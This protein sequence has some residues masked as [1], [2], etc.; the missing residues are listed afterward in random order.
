M[1]HLFCQSARWSLLCRFHL[2]VKLQESFFCVKDPCVNEIHLGNIKSVP[3]AQVQLNI[4]LLYREVEIILF[5]SCLLGKRD[6]LLRYVP[7]DPTQTLSQVSTWLIPGKSWG[8]HERGCWVIRLM[9]K[10]LSR[11]VDWVRISLTVKRFNVIIK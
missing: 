6:K 10:R 11:W 7:L 4:I 9:P 2:A 5:A 3:P 8:V 1:E